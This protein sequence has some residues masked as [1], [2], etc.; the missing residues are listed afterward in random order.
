MM[1]EADDV[2]LMTGGKFVGLEYGMDQRKFFEDGK[3]FIKLLL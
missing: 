1:G 2:S 3:I